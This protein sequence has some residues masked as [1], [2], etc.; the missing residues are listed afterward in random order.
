MVSIP[1][2]PSAAYEEAGIV[3]K[4][5]I[6]GDS[7]VGKSALLNRYCHN[8]FTKNYLAT[9]GV[10]FSL[11][12]LMMDFPSPD[13]GTPSKRSVRLQIWDTAG[14][15]RFKTIAQVYYRGANAIVAAFDLTDHTSFENVENW[16]REV[17]VHRIT[18]D[19]R[20]NGN[21]AV[22]I[23]GTKSDLVTAPFGSAARRAVMR[24]EAENL[25]RE[26]KCAGYF[27]TSALSETLWD[28]D[29]SDGPAK[30]PEVFSIPRADA[31]PLAQM[32]HDIATSIVAYHLETNNLPTVA[33]RRKVFNGGALPPR[34]GTRSGLQKCLR[35]LL[36]AAF[37][38]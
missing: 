2:R 1:V 34:G 19:A 12:R 4:V 23:V 5:V 6:V 27:E 37:D 30:G 16:L 13:G 17:N 32:F 36:P 22:W 28:G 33:E 18:N 20:P 8:I 25:V 24:S 3:A 10:D 7:G 15:D 11:A 35:A 31:T 14:Q 38:W 29:G 9:I 21:A 26:L